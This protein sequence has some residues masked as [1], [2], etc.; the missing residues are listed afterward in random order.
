MD[1]QDI[2]DEQRLV[3]LA[4][5]GDDRLGRVEIVGERLLAK[6][7]R[8]GRERLER[9]RRVMLGIGRDRDRVGLQRRERLVETLEARQAREFLVEIL[10]RGGV[11]GAQAHEL[12]AVDRL[13]GAGV[14]QAHR[15][16]ADDKDAL[17]FR[18]LGR[19]R[20][21]H[22]PSP[23]LVGATPSATRARGR[24]GSARRASA[25]PSR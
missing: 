12:E 9:H 20:V 15:A 19:V 16:E 13:I 3:R 2:A 6:H 25:R 21:A 4:G 1:A 10:S 14:A 11:A 17:P 24:C 18:G 22:R 5:G 7:M 23:L 8:A